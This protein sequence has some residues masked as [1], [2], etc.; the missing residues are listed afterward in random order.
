MNIYRRAKDY[1]NTDTRIMGLEFYNFDNEC[2]NIMVGDC[3]ALR[4]NPKNE[5][6]ENAIEVCVRKSVMFFWSEDVMIGHLTQ[7]QARDYAPLMDSGKSFYAAVGLVKAGRGV[8]TVGVSV[9][10]G[11][12]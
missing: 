5:Y 12:Y 7:S 6:D 9:Y 4:R 8:R 2:G 3:L 1:D 10:E 11:S